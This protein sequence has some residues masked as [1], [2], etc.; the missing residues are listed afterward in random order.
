[1]RMDD[2]L[3]GF[4]L[5]CATLIIILGILWVLSLVLS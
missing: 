3:S 1:M 5:A 2:M 4:M